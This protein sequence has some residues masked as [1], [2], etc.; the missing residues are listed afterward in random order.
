MKES[1]FEP[2]KK[3]L[4]KPK[5]TPLDTVMA[6]HGVVADDNPVTNIR[7][8]HQSLRE[9]LRSG[10]YEQPEGDVLSVGQRDVPELSKL[11]SPEL[12][13]E[14]R[15]I[16]Q[17]FQ[18]Q[19]RKTEGH[20]EREYIDIESGAAEAS[21]IQ[22]IEKLKADLHARGPEK[23]TEEDIASIEAESWIFFDAMRTVMN[24]RTLEKE[25]R[26]F[27]ERENVAKL[28]EADRQ[29]AKHKIAQNLSG[30][31]PLDP[32]EIEILADVID[33]HGQGEAYN[34]EV[35][36][37]T[38]ARLFREYHLVQHKQQ[39]AKISTGHL[40]A[41][42]LESFTPSLF[43][44]LIAGDKFHLEVFLEWFGINKIADL[45]RTW[46]EVESDKMFAEIDKEINQR[47]AESLFFQEFEFIH[48][49]SL[50]EVYE[51]LT[52]GQRAIHSLIS[53]SISKFIPIVSGIGMS[54]GFLAKINPIL[55]AIGL[56]SLPVMYHVARK[57]SKQSWDMRD[58]DRVA[59][60]RVTENLDTVKQGFEEIKSSAEV[61]SVA[62][63]VKA[64]LDEQDQ[65]QLKHSIERTK[66]HLK[67]KVPFELAMVASAVTGGILQH[68]GQISGGAVLSNIMY[69]DRLTGP[70]NEAVDLYFRSFASDIQD[71]QFME[72]ILGRSDQL[73]LPD[74]ERER[75]R[76]PV[77]AL[78]NFNIEVENLSFKGILEGLSLSVQE[79]EFVVVTGPSGVGK[80]TLL[81]NLAGLYAPDAGAVK[82]GGVDLRKI[83]KHGDQSVYRAMSYCNQTPQIF[84]Q[85]T[86]RENLLLWTSQEV[87][88]QRVIEV[89]RELHLEKFI[90]RL[91]AQPENLSGGERVRIGLARTLLKN[92]R[93]ML[94]DEPTASLDSQTATEVRRVIAE[95]H[96]AHPEVTIVCVSHDDEVKRIGDR[97]V[98]L[99]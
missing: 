2:A 78:P 28:P 48:D 81:R 10:T 47:I 34:L 24:T 1:F 61:P 9:Q 72:K 40:V 58:A 90:D 44:G 60:Q 17:R 71:I 84:K 53:N 19:S 73:D 57:Q 29:R 70:V 66:M 89:L 56:S 27:N 86:L 64:Q 88:D 76:I 15:S 97:S 16:L 11:I 45:S 4:A 14:Y 5:A 95:I 49:R 55:G 12:F 7:Q 39:I 67:N 87:E 63:F 77:S 41:K 94:L 59:S 96:A 74:G 36:V 13:A 65:L 35:L 8:I 3:I 51:A 82:L 23:F 21:I 52:R 83:K 33:G 92:P 85:M 75:D 99:T 22:W 30:R 38:I 43:Q 25:I 37:E 6:R 80:S 69:S 98:E 18:M 20:P 50:S 91:D 68:M 62:Q 46:G 31:F 26:E 32:L 54:L 93:I 79:G 42:G